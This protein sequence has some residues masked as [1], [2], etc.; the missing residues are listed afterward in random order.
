MNSKGETSAHKTI[1]RGGAYVHIPFC[2]RKCAYCDF[3]S[4]VSDAETMDAYTQAL[5]RQ[6]NSSSRSLPLTSAYIGGG[7]P[8]VLGADRL[9]RIARALFG[10]GLEQTAEFTVEVNPESVTAELIRALSYAGVNRISMGV[11]SFDDGQLAALGRLADAD[12]CL[13]AY[14]AVLSAGIDNISIDLMLAVPGQDTDSLYRTLRRALQLRP[15]HI[16]AYLLSIEP[17]TRFAAED[18]QTADEDTQA[19]MYLLTDELLTDNGYVHYE[20]SNFA[21]PGM[22]ARHNLNYWRC[23][24]YEAY[25][26]GAHGFDGT[27]RYFYAPDAAEYIRAGGLPEKIIEQRLTAADKLK[28]KIMLGLRTSEGIDAALLHG[29]EISKFD[30]LCR[31]GLAV[32][33]GHGYA[34]TARGFLVSDAVIAEFL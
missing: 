1:S 10:A 16:S 19:Q 32:K 4:F 9:V 31:A 20:I 14:D 24:P 28:E 6:I 2:A 11:Q 7:T 34:L 23:G 22:Q 27:T 26:S 13:R 18:V 30:R 8:S 29:G 25:G 33:T 21:L 3:Y 12:R 5:I 15:A 17:G